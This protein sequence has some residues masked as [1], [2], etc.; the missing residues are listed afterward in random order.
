VIN[1]AGEFVKIDRG[2]RRQ[3]IGCLANANDHLCEFW[4]ALTD[5]V[6][7]LGGGNCLGIGSR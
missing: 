5:T 1:L 4:K 3:G 2:I 7:T 6:E